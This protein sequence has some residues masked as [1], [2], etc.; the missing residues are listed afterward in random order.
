[1]SETDPIVGKWDFRNGNVCTFTETGDVLLEG[2]RN[3][4]WRHV[5]D[6]RYMLVYLRGFWGGA[7]DQLKLNGDAT[8]LN[9]KVNGSMPRDIYRLNGNTQNDSTTDPIVGMWDFNNS[10]I[11]T[12]DDDGW[13]EICGH[14]IGIWRQESE[15][16]YLLLYLRGYFG[17][18]SDPLF[19]ES[20]GNS[21]AALITDSS[22]RK[23]IRMA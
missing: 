1:M 9:G 5:S 8:K 2:E 21:I 11:C 4:V 17:G 16:N 23:L 14:R 13:V 22:T 6:Q 7:S 12:F 18:S 19:L 15:N 20:D 3:G 10:N